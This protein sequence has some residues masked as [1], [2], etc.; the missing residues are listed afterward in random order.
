MLSGNLRL[1]GRLTEVKKPIF[2]KDNQYYVTQVKIKTDKAEM[3]I[4]IVGYVPKRWLNKKISLNE[5][6]KH[7]KE[8]NIRTFEQTSFSKKFPWIIYRKVIF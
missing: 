4:T 6:Y 8:N 2:L 3:P 5:T 1:E 7:N